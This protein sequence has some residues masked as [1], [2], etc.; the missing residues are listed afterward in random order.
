M[1]VDGK[2]V[3]V[4]S[5]EFH[6]FRL[7][8]PTLWSDVLEK[9]KAMGFNAVS[10]YADWALLEGTPGEFRS[11]GIFSV[12][13]FCE[14]VQEV[15]GMW[16]IARPGPYINAEVSGGGFPGWMQ[17]LK[18]RLR[19]MDEDYLAATDNYATKIARILARF[20]YSVG[21]PMIL[22]QPENEYT[23]SVKG[24]TNFPDAS[25]MQYIMDKARNESIKVPFINND[26]W[27]AGHN[28]PFSGLGSVDI[29]GF[30]L[31]PWGLD[32]SATHWPDDALPADLY[33]K[34]LTTSAPTP[35]SIP[36]GGSYDRWGGPG[37]DKCANLFNQ[38]YVRMVY[39][40]NYAA[41]VKILNTY[42]AYGGTNWGNLGVSGG[43]TSYDYGAAIAEDR[44]V[45]REKYSELKLQ[46]NF[47]KVSPDY[48]TAIPDKSYSVGLYSPNTRLAVTRLIGDLGAYYIVRH[49]DDSSTGNLSYTISLETGAQ[50]FQVPYGD[51]T[52]LT[53]TGRDS[54]IHVTQYPVGGDFILTYC[55]A[56]IF[57]WQKYEDR[58]ILVL[59]GGVG[60]L[61]EAVIWSSH[62]D[63]SM[64]PITSKGVTTQKLDD[65]LSRFRW[66]TS[67]SRQTS[68][69]G[70]LYI[71]YLDRNSAY[72][73]W[74]TE[75]VNAG[76]NLI[77]FGGYL[78]RSATMKDTPTTNRTLYLRADVN[79]TTTLEIMGIP[80]DITSLAINNVPTP[81]TITP[82]GA[83][84]TTIQY[85]PPQITLPNLVSSSSTSWRYLDSLPEIQTNYDDSAWPFANLV[86]NNTLMSPQPSTPFSLYG[87]DYGFHS[88]A[89]I[90]RGHFTANGQESRLNLTAQGGNAFA[91]SAWLDGDYLGSWPGN[92]DTD[93]IQLIF[94]LG[95]GGS[96]L[97][98][99]KNYVITVVVD[100][101]GL[102]ENMYVGGDYM[103][104]PRGILDY[105][106][107][108]DDD[109]GKKVVN[110]DIVWKVTGNFNGG[111]KD[112]YVDKARGPLNEGGFYVERMG[113][114]LPGA[115][116][117]V[118]KS[119]MGS[120]FDGGEVGKGAVGFWRSEVELEIPTEE[121]GWRW[122]APL[123]FEF[124]GGEGEGEG[125]EGNKGKQGQ[126]YR[127]LL[128]V[129][130]FQFGRYIPHI[131]PQTSFPVPEGI[132]DYNGTNT[133]GLLVWCT[134]ASGAC[135]AKIG[136]GLELK[137]SG[138]PVLTGRD[139][140]E[141]VMNWGVGGW[142]ARKGAY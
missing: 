60:E 10:F 77:I 115:P 29:Y 32:C 36:E 87:S 31:Y 12:E 44:T 40:N 90:F 15:G 2:R 92:K 112:G 98:R 117:D 94:S 64:L 58:T 105:S 26:A 41:G 1:I 97:D 100:N 71:Y 49:S 61:H 111:Q 67:S 101:M 21:G 70:D 142:K 83:W 123:S 53:L 138:V 91:F 23:N 19:T 69:F 18:G 124:G 27:A 133:I 56:E 137:M 136:G 75:L 62:T 65:G 88:G 113:F 86:T 141:N 79:E 45:T 7:P 126:E 104:A 103:K 131:G 130:G 99:G 16:I 43:Y 54:K 114:H 134:G 8:V 110:N 51:D 106:L 28:V 93:R 3:F 59:Y 122:D 76:T 140:V 132:L 38:E 47:L 128:F 22:Y 50:T 34:H 125:D 63:G 73:C 102:E 35:F 81:F 89:L 9:I 80:R 11:E 55:T 78:I 82:D 129:N 139:K 57:T 6:P 68:R 30:D 33:I 135:G 24:S 84:L 66:T 74:T 17:R 116:E 52:T 85:D 95:G 20:D 39:K 72:K 46:A 5:G 37:Y 118:F 108:G 121:G 127:V 4:F 109:D 48:L 13:K 119:D 25:Y 42:M 96:K 14:V 107:T 120:P